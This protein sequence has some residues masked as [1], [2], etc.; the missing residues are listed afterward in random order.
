MGS[1]EVNME[2]LVAPILC[3]PAK[4]KAQAPILKVPLIKIATHPTLFEGENN[5]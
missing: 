4:K 1:T 3:M 2:A 5:H